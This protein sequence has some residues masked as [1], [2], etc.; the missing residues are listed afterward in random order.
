MYPTQVGIDDILKCLA[1]FEARSAKG[2]LQT[3]SKIKTINVRICS[4]VQRFIL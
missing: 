4:F 3:K 1:K 2:V